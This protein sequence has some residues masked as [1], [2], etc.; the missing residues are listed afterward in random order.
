MPYFVDYNILFI[1]IPKTGGTSVEKYFSQKLKRK[2]SL[3]ELY[4]ITSKFNNHSYQHL[5]YSELYSNRK[6]LNIFFN[7]EML[8]FAVVRN[9]YERTIS[10]LFFQKLIKK[11]MS[12]KEVENKLVNYFKSRD[13]YDYHKIPQYLFVTDINDVINPK[14]KILKT[15]TL[16]NDM[17]LLGFND[18][19]NIETLKTFRNELNY[20]DY[21]T[22]ESIKMINFYY[23]KDFQ[24][25]NYK[26]IN[27]K[28]E[29]D[30]FS[31]N[32]KK[33]DFYIIFLLIFTLIIY[34]ILQFLSYK[35]CH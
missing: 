15:E 29:I 9:P 16:N 8:I 12:P 13:L 24:F 27:T 5:T 21:L 10:E 11:N 25:F 7:S 30:F 18:F 32:N 20:Y 33:N 3:K 28:N 4:S 14:I 23:D 22:D 19:D 35:F 2:L 26:K 1:H 34:L 17:K 31:N 6:L